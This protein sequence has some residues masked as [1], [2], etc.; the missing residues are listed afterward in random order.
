MD[1]IFHDFTKVSLLIS[2]N[3]LE[4]GLGNFLNPSTLSN[5]V[6]FSTTL[7]TTS[8]I[9]LGNR[10]RRGKNILWLF[11][12]ITKYSSELFQGFIYRKAGGGKEGG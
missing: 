10:K 2:K 5:F 9:E 3:H 8:Q 7:N 12:D 4:R 6:S 1:R 11:A